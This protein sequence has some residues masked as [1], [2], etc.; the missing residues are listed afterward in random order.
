MILSGASKYDENV[1]QDSEQRLLASEDKRVNFRPQLPVIQSISTDQQHGTIMISA[2]LE[3]DTLS[4]NP[5]TGSI[6]KQATKKKKKVKVQK[7]LD[8]NQYESEF[9]SVPKTNNYSSA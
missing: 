9:S 2:T 3:D 7:K 4:N 8:I 6:N 1:N 5:D